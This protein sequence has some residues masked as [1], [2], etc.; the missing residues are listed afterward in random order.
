[1]G[2]EIRDS[3]TVIGSWKASN[4]GEEWAMITP[5]SDSFVV[6]NEDSSRY[7][8]IIRLVQLSRSSFVNRTTSR[9]NTG[10]M[11]GLCEIATLADTNDTDLTNGQSE[12][13]L[14]IRNISLTAQGNIVKEP[15]ATGAELMGYG[16]NGTSN[17]FYSHHIMH[18]LTS[19]QMSF[20]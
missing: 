2:G 15:V 6:A 7:Q 1:M 11:F 10:W 5:L 17:Y 8:G 9:Y 19:Q 13:D 16:G 12:T 14:S 20:L 18:S 3:T 4:T